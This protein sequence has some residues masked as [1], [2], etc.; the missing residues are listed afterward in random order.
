MDLWLLI[1]LIALGYV[2]LLLVCGIGAG[3]AL[4]KARREGDLERLRV[5]GRD[6]SDAVVAALDPWLR[7]AN[8]A[9][10]AGIHRTP[11]PD[12]VRRYLLRGTKE[13]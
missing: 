2:A 7:R 3:W 5:A 12:A 11:M 8:D 10:E 4:A 1:P 9:L 6:F 13:A